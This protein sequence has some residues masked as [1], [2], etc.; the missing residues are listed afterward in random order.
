MMRSRQHGF[1]LIELM[2]GT[3]AALIIMLP[4]SM[5]LLHAATWYSDIQSQISVNRHARIA[6]DILLN[7]AQSATTGNDGTKNLY[8]LD[9]LHSAPNSS[10]RSN[11]AFRYR[12]NNLTF[13]PDV[14][15]ALSVTCVA[16]GNPMPDCGSSGTMSVK[17]WIGSDADIE[18]SQRVIAGRTSEIVMTITDPFDAVRNKKNPGVATTTYR[19]VTTQMRDE[20]DP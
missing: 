7:G 10:Y 4:T 8:G 15:A 12:S 17:G 18:T 13:T 9:G 2:F 3:V 16:S 5:L 19:T 14:M 1:T 6:F 11:Y 20:T